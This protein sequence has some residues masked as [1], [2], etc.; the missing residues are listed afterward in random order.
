LNPEN[1]NELNWMIWYILPWDILSLWAWAVAAYRDPGFVVAEHFLPLPEKMDKVDKATL[2][3]IASL[4][5]CER[6]K[7]LGRTG[8]WK[9]EFLHHC[10]AC[11]RCVYGMDHHC[12]WLDNCAGKRTMKPFLLFSVYIAVFCSIAMYHMT[13]I[14]WPKFNYKGHGMT[15]IWHIW[16]NRLNPKIWELDIWYNG[17]G[18]FDAWWF[19]LYMTTILIGTAT[20]AR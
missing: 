6:C 8:I 20:F 4:K 16:Y 5:E 17:W 7:K 19:G 2:E 18:I 11:N 13:Q 9:V 3:R 1:K 15:S 10:G 12:P 14:L